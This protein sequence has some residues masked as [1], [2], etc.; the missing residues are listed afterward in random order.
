MSRAG[1]N[2]LD[3]GS[4]LIA[5][6]KVFSGELEFGL[7]RLV[8]AT[9][10]CNKV[11]LAGSSHHRSPGSRTRKN[12]IIGSNVESHSVIRDRFSRGETYQFSHC[13]SLVK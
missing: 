4:V 10:N 6:S 5:C 8:D 13:R 11:V 9:N 3:G 1:I 12:Q 7:I 2:I